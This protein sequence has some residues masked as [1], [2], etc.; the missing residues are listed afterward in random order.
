MLAVVFTSLLLAQIAPYRVLNIPVTKSGVLLRDAW[1]GGFNS[2]QF[3]TADFNRDGIK[4]LY[5]FDRV[6]DKP[7]V[8][9]NNGTNSDTAFKY[10]PQYESSF[11]TDMTS[12][13]IL[14][15]YNNDGIPD[16]FSRQASPPGTKVYKGSIQNGQLRFDLVSPLLT[17][18][19]VST[20][21]NIYTSIDDIPAYVDVNFD[22]DIDILTFGAFGSFVEYYENQTIET[23]AD[24]DSLP[25]QFKK[26]CWGKF[27]E[28]ALTNSIALN[29][30][31]GDTILEPRYN[32]SRH[33]GSTLFA[34]DDG[35]D[36]D[37]DLLI[38]DISYNTLVFAKN[39][40]DSSNALICEYDSLWP[41]CNITANMP[42]FPAAFPFDVDNDGID[43]IL[44]A[45]NARQGSS[46]IKNILYY[47]ND[48]GVSCAFTRNTNTFLT[49]DILDFGTDSKAILID[50]DGDSLTDILVGNYGYYRQF[51]SYKSTIAFYKNTGTAT[52]PAFT[53]I[54]DDINSISN[55]N[56]V[57]VNPAFGDLDGDN[58]PD[59]V[60]GDF[61]GYIHFFRNNGTNTLDFPAMTTQ[62][63]FGIDAGEYAAPFIY[64]VNHDGLND[65]LVGR[66]DGKISYYWNFGTTTNMQFHRDSSNTLFG[67]INVTLPG[68]VE[69]YAQPY[70]LKDST[71]NE[72][73][74]V[75][76]QR[77][78]I[79]KF[80]IDSTKLRSGSFVQVDTNFLNYVV[81]WRATMQADDLNDDGKLDYICGNSRGGLLFFSDALLDSSI[82]IPSG[83]KEA[84][85]PSSLLVYPNPSSGIVTCVLPKDVSEKYQILLFNI[86]G[87][88]ITPNIQQH[89][90]QQFSIDVSNVP[91]GCYYL[92]YS[93]SNSRITQKIIIQHR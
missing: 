64:D 57:G 10:A 82:L 30:D 79:F 49:D 46:D 9:L 55:Y 81:G 77:G 43:D 14:R 48:G 5:I 87:E 73:L 60:I 41:S 52:S 19:G 86:L 20:G 88:S 6:G 78:T 44:V 89:S 11:P 59:M 39:C 40:G 66:K 28:A 35:L 83:I 58:K 31:C 23:A 18:P 1:N 8:Y 92:Q 61:V 34:F 47:R 32:G 62:Q 56:L 74:Y 33:S 51:S 54:T 45:P 16:I 27:A 36:H 25:Y 80:E 70:I 67:G 13:S 37:I 53:Y 29:V 3:S 72:Q 65:L 4:D 68:R 38:G 91:D 76:S 71:G 21:V 12:W 63:I 69:G 50:F 42:V 84:N 90:T 93:D 26:L 2:P 24:P 75:G 7:L 22:G 17:Y 85:A 15:D